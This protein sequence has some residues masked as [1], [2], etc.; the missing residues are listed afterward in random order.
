MALTG[1]E[2]DTGAVIDQ[3]ADHLYVVDAAMFPF[4]PSAEPKLTVMIP[5]NVLRFG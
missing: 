3:H 4:I 1:A 2:N 5:A